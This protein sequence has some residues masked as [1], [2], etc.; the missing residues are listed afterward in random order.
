MGFCDR[1]KRRRDIKFLGAVMNK[2]KMVFEKR[3]AHRAEK[4]FEITYKLVPRDLNVLPGLTAG[5]LK[6]ISFGGVRVEGECEGRVNDI[7]R[8]HIHP[9][10][11]R[12]TVV[13][14]AQIRWIK[15]KENCP[16]FGVGFL[17]VKEYDEELLKN[18]I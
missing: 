13:M 5:K 11:S 7:I 9:G 8:M 15:N 14:L 18:L 1:L 16:Q 17:G 6:D 3:G 10:N 4:H 12:E 2:A